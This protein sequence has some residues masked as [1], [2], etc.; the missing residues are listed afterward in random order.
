MRMCVCMCANLFVF[1]RDWLLLLHVFPV[2]KC[3][4]MR[5]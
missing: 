2:Q 1:S 4:I 5:E 3:V